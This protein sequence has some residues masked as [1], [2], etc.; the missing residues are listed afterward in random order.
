[1]KEMITAFTE[2]RHRDKPRPSR[3]VSTLTVDCR[4]GRN[5][6]DKVAER[7]TESERVSTVIPSGYLAPEGILPC[8]YGG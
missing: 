7:D 8:G 4:S 2:M 3:S 6:C 5:G 1:M